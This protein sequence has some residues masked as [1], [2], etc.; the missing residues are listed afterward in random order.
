ME[1]TKDILFNT[2]ITE[3]LEI[4]IKA[5]EE[6]FKN[7]SQQM[8]E[9]A[10]GIPNI[11]KF[12]KTYID[13]ARQEREVQKILKIL[14]KQEIPYEQLDILKRIERK[15]KRDNRLILIDAY[16]WGVM[17]GKREERAR[18]KTSNNQS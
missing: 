15:S 1:K 2:V 5:T 16:Q 17:Q 4:M 12:M 18:K 11:E 6:D 7:K 8:L 14:G 9:S 3:W 13:A 10:K